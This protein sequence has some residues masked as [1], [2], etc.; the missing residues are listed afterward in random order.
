LRSSRR[1]LLR[2]RAADQGVAHRGRARW[3]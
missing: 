2:Q 3:P 1:Q